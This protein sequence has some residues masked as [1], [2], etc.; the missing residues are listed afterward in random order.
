MVRS[1]A[2]NIAHCMLAAWEGA[3]REVHVVTQNVDDLHQRAGSSR[4]YPLHGDMLMSTCLR[5]GGQTDTVVL[6]E[7]ISRGEVPHCVCGGVFKPDITF[8]GEIVPQAPWESAVRVVQQA[9]LL[10]V[11]ASSLVVYPAAYLPGCRP[12]GSKLVMINRG[13]TMLDAEADLLFSGDLICVFE[14]LRDRNGP[15]V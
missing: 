6:D 14:A 3:G 7:V 12:K 9:E 10:V 1:A 13:E 2:P 11:I 5:C 8:F 15:P 4:V